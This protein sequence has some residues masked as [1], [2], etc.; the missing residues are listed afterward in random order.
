MPAEVTERRLPNPP[1]ENSP[2]E[3]Q[4]DDDVNG[5]TDLGR[6]LSHMSIAEN[7]FVDEDQGQEKPA[8]PVSQHSRTLS[9][10]SLSF[11][12]SA[13]PEEPSTSI[14][15]EALI[16]NEPETVINPLSQD[17]CREKT[18]EDDALQNYIP[19]TPADI[20]DWQD[21]AGN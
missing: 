7:E 18:P 17:Y 19:P 2:A 12:R 14:Q 8:S 21:Q 5:M 1:A 15:I 20:M 11:Y 3:N 10:A 6:S 16:H 13:S 4:Q 9:P